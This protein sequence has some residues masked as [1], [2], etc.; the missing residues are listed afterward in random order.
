VRDLF[1]LRLIEWGRERNFRT[2]NLGLAPLAALGE[3]SQPRVGERMAKILFQHGE[4]WNNFRGIRRS[5]QKYDPQWRARYLAYPASWIWPQ[6]ILNVAAL[7]AGGWRNVVFPNEKQ[8]GGDE[9]LR[10]PGPASP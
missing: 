6:V 9:S 8:A 7:I 5:K 2:F 10:A 4:Y 1:L 3:S